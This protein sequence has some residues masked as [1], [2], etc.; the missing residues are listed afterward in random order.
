M[1][2]PGGTDPYQGTVVAD[3]DQRRVDPSALRN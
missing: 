3:P 2:T 1:P